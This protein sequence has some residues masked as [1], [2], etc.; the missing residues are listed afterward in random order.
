LVSAVFGISSFVTSNGG[1]TV[2]HYHG[3]LL[4]GY[5]ALL[6]CG[7]LYLARMIRQRRILAWRIVLLGSVIAWANFVVAGTYSIAKQYPQESTRDTI[8]FAAMLAVISLPV[9]IYWAWRWRKQ[10][11]YFDS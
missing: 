10:K 4:R 1:Y 11:P 3:Y 5:A 2:S 8:L 7:L 9:F 6:G